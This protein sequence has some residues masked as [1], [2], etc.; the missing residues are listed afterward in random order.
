M[1]DRWLKH[2]VPLFT[3]WPFKQSFSAES[4]CDDDAVRS[5]RK[6]NMALIKGAVG[7]VG[8][9]L[10]ERMVRAGD[11]GNNLLFIISKDGKTDFS[12]VRSILTPRVVSIASA[13]FEK[14]AGT[15]DFILPYMNL[16]IRQFDPTRSRGETVIPFHQ[17]AFAFPNGLSIINCWTLLYPE[18]CGETSPGLDFL[19]VKLRAPIKLEAR[20]ASETY[21]FLESSHDELR[22]LEGKQAPI[23]PSVRIGDVLMF[24]ELAVH[25]TSLHDGL[26][27]ARVSAEVRL[28]AAT[29]VAMAE[30]AVLNESYA[31]VSGRRITWP[32]RWRVGDDGKFRTVSSLEADLYGLDELSVRVGS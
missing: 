27:Q 25:R 9:E 19:P 30:R 13:Y 28:I 7:R 3:M 15:R 17:D 1:G 21:G 10:G 16:Q 26:T 5:L 12:L 29:P 11:P 4:I 31:T 6:R 18:E 20:P 8:W 24:N 2:L 23:T 14:V 22:R 32:C